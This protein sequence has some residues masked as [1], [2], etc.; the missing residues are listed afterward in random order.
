M[1]TYAMF[2]F[3]FASVKNQH[4]EVK[5]FSNYKDRGTDYQNKISFIYLKLLVVLWLNI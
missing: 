4:P 2:S 1:T 5:L 3:V